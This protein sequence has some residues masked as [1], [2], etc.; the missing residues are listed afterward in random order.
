MPQNTEFEKIEV[1]IDGAYEVP[2]FIHGTTKNSEWMS[3]IRNHPAPWGELE[4]PNHLTIT[5]PSKDM[6]EVED[7]EALANVYDKMMKHF[8]ELMG[9]GKMQRHERMVFDIQISA[10][11][12]K[13]NFFYY[14]RIKYWF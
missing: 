1:S 14:T 7:M 4:I 12:K 13:V 10:G 3:T 6:R 9:T 8:V 11:M 2:Y 5:F